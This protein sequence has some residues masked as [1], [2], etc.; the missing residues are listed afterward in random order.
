MLKYIVSYMLHVISCKIVTSYIRRNS[1][2]FPVKITFLGTLNMTG[3]DHQN[4][5]YQLVQ[6]CDVYLHAKNKFILQFKFDIFATLGM[7]QRQPQKDTSACRQ[8]GLQAK[9]IYSFLSWDIKL[10]YILIY[11]YNHIT[12][13]THIALYNNISIK[14]LCV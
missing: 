13:I 9:F 3:Y 1:S 12:L 2:Y 6:N 5:R 14:G 11:Y 4:E 10:Y 8:I 7:L